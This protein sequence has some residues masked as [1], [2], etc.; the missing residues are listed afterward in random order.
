MPDQKITLEIVLAEDDKVAVFA[1]YSG[2]MTG[3]MGE[4]AA[5]G[6]SLTSRFLAIFRIEEGRIA[7]L[8][9]EMDN[10]AMFN[11]LG[12]SPAPTVGSE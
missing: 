6:R 2:T 1:T 7:E 4:F 8:W 11:Q 5:T 3:S 9:I 10:L 12:L